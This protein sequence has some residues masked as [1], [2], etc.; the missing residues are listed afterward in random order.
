MW[1]SEDFCNHRDMACAGRPPRAP[2][3][4]PCAAGTGSRRPGVA[5][6]AAARRWRAWAARRAAGAGPAGRGP[7]PRVCSV[8]SASRRSDQAPLGS[9]WARLAFAACSFAGRSFS[10]ASVSGV[11]TEAAGLPRERHHQRRRPASAQAPSSGWDREKIVDEG[12]SWWPAA[13]AVSASRSLAG[14]KPH[15]R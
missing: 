11:A 1:R 2:P 6:S 15:K 14:D 8:A 5:G 9:V 7:R 3:T 13:A 4:L 10:A 12:A